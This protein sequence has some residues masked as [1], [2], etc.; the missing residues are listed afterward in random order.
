M[1][2]VGVPSVG[3]HDELLELIEHLSAEGST[4]FDAKGRALLAWVHAQ[5]NGR[6]E[7]LLAAAGFIPEAYDHDSS[8]EKV[9]AKAM[10]IL[11]A[12]AFQR[13]GFEAEVSQ[14]RSNSADVLARAIHAESPY[15]V[16]LDA[17]AFRLSRTALN[18]KDYKIEALN[19]WRRGSDYAVLVGPIAGFP[20]GNSRLFVEAARFSVTLLTFSHLAFLLH[21]EAVSIDALRNL[22]DAAQI[23]NDTTEL[24]AREY[25]LKIDEAFCRAADVAV[26]EW[27]LYRRQY[28]E[29]LI[30]VADRQIEFYLSQARRIQ[31]MDRDALA[32]LTIKAL[33]LDSRIATISQRKTK[34]RLLLD[35]VDSEEA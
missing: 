5:P 7:A 27:K 11:V 35:A 31:T 17:K 28:F 19:T 3:A 4:T 21:L 22:W 24:V 1:E 32:A 12:V 15:S 6:L 18:P 14:E 30:H 34:T 16:V 29:T 25:W 20:E 26:S 9:Y 10:D 23:A 33:K 8:E 2:P 13:M